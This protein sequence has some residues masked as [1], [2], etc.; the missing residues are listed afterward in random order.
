MR[1]QRCLELR[2]LTNARYFVEDLR[3]SHH[4]VFLGHVSRRLMSYNDLIELPQSH[5]RGPSPVDSVGQRSAATGSQDQG[6]RRLISP[7]SGRRTPPRPPLTPVERSRQG[8]PD[9]AL[10]S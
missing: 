7:D 9:S 4:C 2:I 3:V 6:T 5:G 8:R 10:L 1:L